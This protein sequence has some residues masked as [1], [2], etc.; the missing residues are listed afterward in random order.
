MRAEN[1]TLKAT[2]RMQLDK[3]E[4]VEGEPKMKRYDLFY[5]ENNKPTMVERPDGSGQF[6]F[7][8]D[9]DAEIARLND[10][11]TCGSEAY[12]SVAEEL[13][14]LRRVLTEL[15]AWVELAQEDLGRDGTKAL[16]LIDA[17][18]VAK[19]PKT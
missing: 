4:A 19:E 6:V 5:D 10:E 13:E 2:L 14:R 8:K 9:A 16:A 3:P 15:R 18:A 7:A 11:L 1:E 12:H 17:L